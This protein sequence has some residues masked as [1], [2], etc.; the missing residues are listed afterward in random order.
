LN[1]ETALALLRTKILEAKESKE[2]GTINNKRKVQ[3]G[4]GMRGDKIRTIRVFD[5]QV[6]DH[7]TKKSMRFNKYEKGFIEGLYV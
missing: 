2:K 4:S 6:K 1:K 7:I 3:I 5:N